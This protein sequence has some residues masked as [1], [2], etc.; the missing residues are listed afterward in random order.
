MSF[1][2]ICDRKL[3]SMF[4]EPVW[5]ACKNKKQETLLEGAR[6]SMQYRIAYI[7]LNWIHATLTRR[8]EKAAAHHLKEERENL[9]KALAWPDIFSKMY[10]VSKKKLF[11]VTTGQVTLVKCHC[12]INPSAKNGYIANIQWIVLVE[13]IRNSYLCRFFADSVSVFLLTEN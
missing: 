11:I 1:M 4:H 13:L 7:V 5:W 2:S 12:L 9:L 6:C 3:F 8:E 10:P